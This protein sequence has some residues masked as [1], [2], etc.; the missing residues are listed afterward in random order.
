MRSAVLLICLAACQFA[1]PAARLDDA[2]TTAGS[3]D[4]GDAPPVAPPDAC[5]TCPANDQAAGAIPITESGQIEASLAT[6][7]DDLTTCGPAGGRDLFYE[8]TVATAQVVYV[9]T[10]ASTFDGVLSIHPGACTTASA[11]LACVDNP[12]A[13][14]THA[15]LARSL[16]P[17][18]YCLVVDE[19]TAGTAADLTLDVLFTERAGIELAGPGP[20]TMTGDTCATGLDR[21]DP[22]CESGAAAPGTAKDV[23]Y[24]FAVCP[25]A[26]TIRASTC[27]GSGYDSI[28]YLSSDSGELGCR[29]EGCPSGRGSLLNTSLTG[30]GLMMVTVDGWDGDCGTYSLTVTP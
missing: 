16:A 10:V 14:A 13:P 3:D 29:D 23:M 4:G 27:T 5:A 2:S 8:I 25:G 28:V 20:W 6:A 15:Q 22:S 30:N 9:D 19:G 18:T 7:R 11:P 17:G 12:C 21:V 1:P 24:W 26:H